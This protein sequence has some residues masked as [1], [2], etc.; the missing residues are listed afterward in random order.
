MRER[1]YTIYPGITR[2]QEWIKY[3]IQQKDRTLTNCYDRKRKFR[4]KMDDA[5]YRTA[6]DWIPQSTVA[7]KINQEGI[8]FLYENQQWFAPVEL[9]N[10]I[11]DEIWFQ[12]SLDHP[13]QTHADILTR[14]RDSL[15]TPIPW[16][17]SNFVIP[18]NEVKLS[19]K[20]FKNMEKA[21]ISSSSSQEV[22]KELAH[23]YEKF[24]V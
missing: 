18:V 12:I 4:E 13:W 19:P 24:L 8:R 3:A 22:S 11:H 15:S 6:Y 9:L 20:N 16:E 5:L 10:Q 2:M 23:A 1:Y 14:L 21:D 7:H 17:G